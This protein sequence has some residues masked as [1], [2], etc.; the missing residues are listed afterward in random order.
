VPQVH[1]SARRIANEAADEKWRRPPS[2]KPA[3]EVQTS[4]KFHLNTS[5]RAPKHNILEVG[6]LLFKSATPSGNFFE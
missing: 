5:Q 1:Q 3:D 4:N 2:N 6:F